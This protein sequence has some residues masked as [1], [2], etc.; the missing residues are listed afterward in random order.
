MVIE[1][2]ESQEFDM[3]PL[4]YVLQLGAHGNH[5][6][7]ENDRIREAFAKKED[8][9]ADLGSEHVFQVRQAIR[10]VLAIPEFEG[11]KQFISSLPRDIQHV[12]IFLY[13]QMIEKSIYLDH[14]NYH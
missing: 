14:K 6:L 2:D 5:V 7:F 10:E 1:F 9:L 12:L 11:K 4:E 3:S 13:F 8:E